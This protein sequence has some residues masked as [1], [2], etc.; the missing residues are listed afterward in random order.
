[1]AERT[2]VVRSASG[3]HA[4]P[5]ALFVKAAAEHPFPIYVRNADGREVEGRSI[6]GVLALRVESGATVTLRAEGPDA[7]A[8]LDALATLLEQDLDEPA[9][10]AAAAGPAHEAAKGASDAA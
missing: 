5:A 1:V 3:L 2:V 9:G 6:L 8:A 10:E 7:D 4:R